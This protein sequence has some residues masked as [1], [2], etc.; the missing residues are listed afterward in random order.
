MQNP[1]FTAV[2][3]NLVVKNSQLFGIRHLVRRG[4]YQN[5]LPFFMENVLL[6]HPGYK[7]WYVARTAAI[8]NYDFGPNSVLSPLEDR[9]C[10][11]DVLHITTPF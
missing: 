11:R 3:A 8:F 5:L 6:Y 4:L 10:R 7:T 9:M 1:F 2:S